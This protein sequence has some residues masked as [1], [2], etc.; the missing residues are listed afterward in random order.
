MLSRSYFGYI[1]KNEQ[2]FKNNKF[3]TM[4]S[5]QITQLAKQY[6]D[7]EVNFMLRKII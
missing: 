7:T 1:I 5:L 2:F 6:P 4:L 3:Y